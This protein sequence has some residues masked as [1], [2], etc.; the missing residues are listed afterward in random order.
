MEGASSTARIQWLLYVAAGRRG[1]S[2]SR[3]IRGRCHEEGL[4]T[5]K[6]KDGDRGEMGRS[7]EG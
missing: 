4:Y 1:G 2:R 7:Q 5:A 6:P 3:F